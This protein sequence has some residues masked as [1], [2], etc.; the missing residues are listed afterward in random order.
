MNTVDS[1]Y[2][3]V[4][5]NGLF[6]RGNVHDGVYIG[7]G[8]HHNIVDANLI[9]GNDFEGVCNV[10]YAK[11][12]P[13]VTTHHNTIVNNIIGLTINLTPLGNLTG[14]VSIGKYGTQ[15]QGGFATDNIVV[16]NKIAHN[17][18]N[19]IMVWEHWTNAT[20]ADRNR[21][22]QNSIYNNSLLGIDL[23]DNSITLNDPG[24]PDNGANQEL[25]FPVITSARFGVGGTT[26]SGTLDIGQNPSTAIIELFKAGTDLSGY[27]EGMNYW[28]FVNPGSSGSW[29]ITLPG[30]V[31]GDTVTATAIDSAG[32][33]SEFAQ[34]AQVVLG[35]EEN[36][37]QNQKYPM[38]SI[39]PNPAKTS[40]SVSIPSKGNLYF[41][42]MYNFV[43]NLIRQEEMNP[44]QPRVSVD[45]I[46]QGIYFLQI[47]NEPIFYKL[48]ITK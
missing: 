30:L 20:N 2:I 47:N 1:N 24:D 25:N 18:R 42:K 40:F 17:T 9:S 28:G 39:F 23:G 35:I 5:I 31:V 13:P 27:G 44:L 22:T 26:I 32:N 34:N 15:Y 12:V 45:D 41:L 16:I 3:G 36:N 4:D 21:I 46:E 6:D 48:I 38:L 11:A 43:G 37:V 19:G 33:T 14:G 7:E 10:G 8:A 29:N